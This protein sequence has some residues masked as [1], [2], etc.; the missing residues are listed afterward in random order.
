MERR[1]GTVGAGIGSGELGAGAGARAGSGSGQWMGL[2]MRQYHMWCGISPHV[3]TTFM[4]Y[5]I[6]V[7]KMWDVVWCGVFEN[8]GCGM[9]CGVFFV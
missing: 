5:H 3:G 9:W 8:V 4:W 7:G 6:N 1:C 2:E